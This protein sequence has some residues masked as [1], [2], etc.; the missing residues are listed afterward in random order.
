MP[1]LKVCNL[2]KSVTPKPKFFELLELPQSLDF[3]DSITTKLKK[4]QVCQL[5]KAL[6]RDL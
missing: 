6:Q 1:P 5:V 4:P 2:F 3:S